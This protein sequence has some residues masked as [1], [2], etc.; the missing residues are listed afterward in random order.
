MK[1]WRGTS[2]KV[3][4]IVVYPSRKG[5]KLWM[6]QGIVISLNP[7]TVKKVGAQRTSHPSLERLTVI[8]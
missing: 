2:I 1:D 4:S 5:A 8:P 6:T 7:L 3:G